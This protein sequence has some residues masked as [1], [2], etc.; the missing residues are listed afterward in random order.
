MLQRICLILFF[1]LGCSVIIS[2]GQDNQVTNEEYR[3]SITAPT[4]SAPVKD[5]TT[6]VEFHGS[7]KNYGA[8]ARFFLKRVMP[9]SNSTVEKVES[10]MKEA[11]NIAAFDKQ[12]IDSMKI[13]FPDTEST[14]KGF[15]VFNDRPAINGEFLFTVGKKSMKG[16]YLIVLVKE[17]SSL[18]VFSWST[19][20][21]SF[22][23][24]NAA[25]ENSVKSLKVRQLV[26]SSL[27]Y[28]S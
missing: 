25:S 1:V 28:L 8:D 7:R 24:W 22:E 18:Y 6:I 3:F 5:G 15:I 4:D 20:T 9:F 14:D 16:R 2:F 23:K 21:N 19:K 11:A 10:Y 13:S 17:Q 27:T 12:L 26:L